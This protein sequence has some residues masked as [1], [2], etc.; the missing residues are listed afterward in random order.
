MTSWRDVLKIHHA[1][2]EFP[3][4]DEKGQKELAGD[5]KRN[6]QHEPVTLFNI[7][8]E[9]L[10]GDGITRLDVQEQI[11][12]QI[13]VDAD[14]KLTVSHR[15]VELPDDKAAIAYVASLNLHRRHL[16]AEQK[17][18]IVARLLAANPEKSDRAIA[19]TVKVDH[20]TVGAVRAE[21]EAAGEI[22]QSKER[23]GADGKKRKPP[24]K[25]KTAPLPPPPPLPPSAPP[26]PPSLAATLAAHQAVVAK[27]RDDVGP[28][29]SGEAE[30]LRARNEELEREVM[31]L[32]RINSALESEIEELKTELARRAAA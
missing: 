21:K 4:P 14:G 12:G 27:S 20:K 26:L 23:T 32:K 30:R 8:G 6:G 24:K 7:G 29:S 28:T 1:A 22:P 5:I 10:L 31:R 18:K 15:V 13:V 11:L 25:V 17:R 2:A 9:I 19:E 16:T 3:R